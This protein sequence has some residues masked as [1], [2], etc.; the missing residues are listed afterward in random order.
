MA[1]DKEREEGQERPSRPVTAAARRE[2]R[3]RP[4]GKDT[5]LPGLK[6]DA[7]PEGKASTRTDAKRDAKSDSKSKADVKSSKSVSE[8]KGKATPTRDRKA[9]R[10]GI[11]ARLVRF[12][13]EVVAELR[14][15][16]WPTRK[17]ML[18][19]SVVVLIFLAFMVALVAGLDVGLAKLVFL[20]FGD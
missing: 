16:I 19:Y 12:L 1:E 20:V 3:A 13:R 18:T 6:G 5:G 7:K 2:R 17:Q 10:P 9:D 8:R 4:A 14:K 15:V 11:L